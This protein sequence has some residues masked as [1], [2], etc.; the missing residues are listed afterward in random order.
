MLKVTIKQ[1]NISML[2]LLITN[3]WYYIKVSENPRHL[4]HYC[5]EECS[6]SIL[7]FILVIRNTRKKYFIKDIINI[8]N[9][10]LVSYFNA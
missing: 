8:I 1:L 4:F 3:T 9:K 7:I 5:N 2:N 10:Y 6:S